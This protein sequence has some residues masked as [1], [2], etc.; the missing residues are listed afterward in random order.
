MSEFACEVVR[1]KLEPHP[2]ADAIEICRVGDYQSIVRKG[3]F[4]DGD[5]AVY[6]P[7]QA[8][9]PT[10][11]LREMGMYDEERQKGGLAGGLGNRV[12]AIKLRGVLSQGLMYNVPQRLVLEGDDVAEYLDIFKYEPAVPSHM[13]GR[14]I[15]K[16][17]SEA[18]L[19]RRSG[20]EFN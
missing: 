14:K 13:R 6:I 8:I 2:N 4:Q 7:E 18:Y 1:V 3:Q 19:L 12:K 5:L 11:M 9:V 10:W 16:S 20:T 15:A 17:V